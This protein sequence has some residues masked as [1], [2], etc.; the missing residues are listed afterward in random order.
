[1]GRLGSARDAPPAMVACRLFL[2]L[3]PLARAVQIRGEAGVDEDDDEAGD[4]EKEWR[5]RGGGIAELKA[6]QERRRAVQDDDRDGGQDVELRE[7]A[8]LFNDVETL[9]G[10]GDRR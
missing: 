1:M 4:R 8:L 9:G 3:F 7:A 5:R 10:G 2:E 6:A